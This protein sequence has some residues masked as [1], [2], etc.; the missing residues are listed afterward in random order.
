MDWRFGFAVKLTAK[1]KII[2]GLG[3]TGLLALLLRRNDH[4]S[5]EVRDN[6]P[7]RE[8]ITVILEGKRPKTSTKA[9]L[10]TRRMTVFLK[11]APIAATTI[12]CVAAFGFGYVVAAGSLLFAAASLST[13]FF[14]KQTQSNGTIFS[15]PLF[16]L[17][18]LQT[19]IIII[20]AGVGISFIVNPSRLIISII[21][22][23]A[24]SCLAA[25]LAAKLMKP[26][27]FAE[28]AAAAVSALAII[29][30]CIPGL[31]AFTEELN[32]PADDGYAV[33]FVGGPS[34]QSVTLDAT[35]S[36]L[37]TP[38]QSFQISSKNPKGPIPWVLLLDGSAR[39]TH[40]SDPTT[41]L[42]IRQI[43]VPMDSISYAEVTGGPIQLLSGLVGPGS[44]PSI[45]GT[46][47]GSFTYYAS[48]QIGVK[49]PNYEIGNSDTVSPM[50]EAK[51]VQL[52]GGTPRASLAQY[53]TV[54]VF[55]E[56]NALDT[57]TSSLPP[58][59]STSSQYGE[60]EWS[61][62]FGEPIL[63]SARDQGV[64]GLVSDALFFIAFL[65][66]IAGAALLASLQSAIHLY[67]SGKSPSP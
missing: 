24:G 64:S 45:S 57:V 65:L 7:E 23:L 48:D 27:P 31:I 46:A 59:V 35:M 39:M 21:F 12:A 17:A 10:T 62:N 47:I 56:G 33:L 22:G 61:S 3:V 32:F 15:M 14:R 13:L 66:G 30:I 43:N 29:L 19:L 36:T 16:L 49:L 67:I 40:I 18:A 44:I 2:V 53:S 54:N 58:P 51:I 42:A 41:R 4:R 6:G 8:S 20:V 37:G 34:D 63:Y 38:F 25:I 11:I 28:P 52:L 1:K 55:A 60:L 26:S 5:Q 50:L 9:S